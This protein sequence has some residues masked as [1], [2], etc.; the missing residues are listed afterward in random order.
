MADGIEGWNFFDV[1]SGQLPDESAPSLLPAGGKGRIVVLAATAFARQEGWASRAAVLIAGEWAQEG[2]RVFLMDLGLED[3]TLH[4]VLGLPNGEGVSDAFLF[5]ASIQ[6]VAKGALDNAIFFAPAGAPPGD[7]EEVLGHPRWNDLAGGFSEADATLVLFLPTEI[8]G[9]GKILSR[10]TDILFLAA[11]GESVDTHLGPASIKVLTTLGP[12]GTPDTGADDS[13]DQGEEGEPEAPEGEVGL[14]MMDGVDATLDTSDF[15]LEGGI[16]LAEG[17]GTED[18][19][20][21]DG[22]EVAPDSDLGL[23]ELPQAT[24]VPDDPPSD[25]EAVSPEVLDSPIGEISGELPDPEAV[26]EPAEAAP[27]AV[28]DPAMAEP[29][30]DSGFGADLQMGADL[31]EEVQSTLES[32]ADG[33]D[34]KPFAPDFGA[35]FVDL[36]PADGLVP[37][38]APE[39]DFAGDL[40]Q[41]PDFGAP[42]EPPPIGG[43]PP[44]PAPPAL[45][46]VPPSPAPEAPEPERRRPP[47]KKAPRKK[48]PWAGIG[49]VALSVG[50]LGSAVGTA[51]GYLDVPGFTFLRNMFSEVPDPP[52]TLAGPEANEEILR[53]S[54]VLFTYDQDGLQSGMQMLDALQ[55]RLPDLL[56]TL[57]PGES[58]GEKT[59]TLLAGPA[60]DRVE[61]EDLRGVVAE[62]LTRE[63]PASWSVR[64]TPRAFYLGERGSLRD[65]QDYLDSVTGGEVYA[66]IL[67]VTFPTTEGADP[68]AEG[69][70]SFQ[71]L[72][73]AFSGVQDARTLQLILR[74]RG[75]RDAPL[76]ER[77]GRL[78][79]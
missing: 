21:D 22:I 20:P 70:E 15:D 2:L 61:A 5:G 41:G 8:P 49:V 3:P 33:S 17:F 40:V 28:D 1:E 45:G 76:I 79:E 9:A 53:Y 48:I 77:R 26:E 11:R 54:L 32:A 16:E 69:S 34:E 12:L 25:A 44:T 47:R 27:E 62:V 13:R 57:V 51:M 78:P 74:D 4:Q 6:H 63:D 30:L 10:A 52:L 19:P 46:E 66:Y 75:F 59:Y 64:E 72:S 23:G 67:H 29:S 73:G 60:S 14:E 58:G 24:E 35:D 68:E 18:P 50:I 43:E 71:I 7:P 42:V 37:S 39:G 55:E 38:G 65:A 31:V 56:L 36:P